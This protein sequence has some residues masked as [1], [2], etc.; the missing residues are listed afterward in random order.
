MTYILRI[1]KVYDS[2]VAYESEEGEEEED[3]TIKYMTY[4]LRVEICI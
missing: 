1:E 3:D 4:I 2:D